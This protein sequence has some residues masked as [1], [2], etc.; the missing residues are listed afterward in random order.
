MA[1]V[2][3]DTVRGCPRRVYT[4]G[5]KVARVFRLYMWVCD[6]FLLRSSVPSLMSDSS[7]R[8]HTASVVLV[9]VAV[10]VGVQLLKGEYG[11]LGTMV[12]ASAL[13]ALWI[14]AAL[15]SR[16]ALGTLPYG[17]VAG[18]AW[19][20]ITVLLFRRGV[21][22][23]LADTAGISAIGAVLYFVLFRHRLRLG[24]GI[25]MAAWVF[26]AFLLALAAWI[27]VPS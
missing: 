20:G 14:E 2:H 21:P 17:L 9:S 18:L 22:W 24:F 10:F 26:G 12:L 23:V 15:K 16:G 19:V 25:Y 13:F 7:V 3:S 27:L 4:R 11:A 6:D 1:R 5:S 8:E